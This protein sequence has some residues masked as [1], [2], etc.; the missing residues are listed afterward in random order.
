MSKVYRFS[1]L[2]TRGGV[3][4]ALT[5]HY[6]TDLSVGDDEPSPSNVL[7]AIGDHHTT[8][9]TKWLSFF[10]LSESDVTFHTASLV[11]RVLPSEI[12]S[13]AVDVIAHI[14]VNG[15]PGS[16]P[17]EL[18]AW[19]AVSG[20]EATRSA[21]GGMHS[22]PI[23][24]SAAFSGGRFDATSTLGLSM[25]T[26]CDQLL[27]SFDTGGISGVAI[28]PVVYSRTRHIRGLTPYTFRITRA[29]VSTKPRFMRSRYS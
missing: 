11:E 23:T 9:A 28:H 19:I 22:G 17:P 29:V 1:L 14:G 24:R 8:S 27:D 21:R 26:V 4:T 20:D 15:S 25:Q 12:A 7:D 2:G 6:Q 18:A 16:M 10:D 13:S 5:A 3:E